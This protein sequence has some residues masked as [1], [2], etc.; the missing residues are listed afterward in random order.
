MPTMTRRTLTGFALALFALVLIFTTGVMAEQAADGA[1]SDSKDVLTASGPT[2][3]G[4]MSAPELKLSDLKSK[5][6]QL[7]DIIEELLELVDDE[8]HLGVL[9]SPFQKG[10]H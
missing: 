3:D 6:H 10:I 8:E 5:R 9:G 7:S 2:A 4:T 1:G